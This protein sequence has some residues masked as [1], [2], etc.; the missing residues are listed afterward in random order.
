VNDP[1]DVNSQRKTRSGNGKVLGKRELAEIYD[2]YYLPI[3]R[4][5]FRQ[6]GDVDVSRELTS[7][8]FH[9][10]LKQNQN[11]A[12]RLEHLTPWLYCVARNLV[13]DHYR[14]QQY[15]NHFSLNDEIVESSHNT[16]EIAEIQIT[17]EKVRVALT[18]LT[19]D[20]RHVIVLKFIEG[21]S[22]QE[23]ADALS[24]PVGAVKALQHRGLVALRHLLDPI[25]ERIIA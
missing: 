12:D 21:L 22:N 16:A 3:Y 8:V 1:K 24:K 17:T 10:L 4:Y 18:K 14:R 19:P 5:I 2:Q 7:E 6:I 13:I 9:R 20:Q 11:G 23:V 25:E 15:R